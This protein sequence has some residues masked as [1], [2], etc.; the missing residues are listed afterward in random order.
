[1]RIVDCNRT[2]FDRANTVDHEQSIWGRSWMPRR[3][4]EDSGF[5][6]TCPIRHTSTICTHRWNR[7][8]RNISTIRARGRRRNAAS[9]VRYR[10]VATGARYYGKDAAAPAD[11]RTRN[12]SSNHSSASESRHLVLSPAPPSK[13]RYHPTVP[14]RLTVQDL[15][16]VV[17]PARRGGLLASTCTDI[18]Q[19]YTF[20]R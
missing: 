19:N 1:M 15:A 7:T 13:A 9:T 11:P 8:I 5:Q 3:R 16:T 14:T 4:V 20:A 12:R 6:E 10:P 2:H 17:M 18:R